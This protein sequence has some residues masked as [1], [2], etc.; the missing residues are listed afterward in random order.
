M[1]RQPGTYF[2]VTL[3]ARAPRAEAVRALRGFLK[4]AL[5]GWQLRCVSAVE[6]AT[7]AVDGRRGEGAAKDGDQ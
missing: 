2:R 5:R 1:N 7:P 3:R 6:V 4:S